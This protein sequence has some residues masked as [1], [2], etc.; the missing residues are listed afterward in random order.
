MKQ[1]LTVLLAVALSACGATPTP[2]DAVLGP[3]PADS[4]F[5]LVVEPPP[6]GH[7]ERRLGAAEAALDDVFELLAQLETPDGES[8][9]AVRWFSAIARRLKGRM[10]GPGLAE[11]GMRQGGYAALFTERGLPVLRME[12]TSGQ[13]F[14]ETMRSLADAARDP[15]PERVWKG[16]VWWDFPLPETP[17][18]VLVVVDGD[19]LVVAISM[20]ET[21]TKAL[22]GLV[23][24]EPVPGSLADEPRLEALRSEHGFTWYLGAVE[25]AR[26]ASDLVARIEERGAWPEH[27]RDEVLGILETLPSVYYGVVDTGDAEVDK[28]RVLVPLSR[29]ARAELEAIVGP[30]PGLAER[31]D[32]AFRA[33][34][35]FGLRVGAVLAWLRRVG[36]TIRVQ[37]YQ[38][39]QLAPLNVFANNV[40]S[41]LLPLAATPVPGLSGVSAAISEMAF[42]DGAPRRFAGVLILGTTDGAQLLGLAALSMPQLLPLVPAAGEAFLLELPAEIVGMVG[43]VHVFHDARTIG[44]SV[45]PGNLE[46]MQRMLAVESPAVEGFAR[47]SMDGEFFAKAERALSALDEDTADNPLGDAFER[48]QSAISGVYARTDVVYQ[49]TETGFEVQTTQR[50]KAP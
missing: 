3:I 38:C 46:R 22:P 9:R 49:L 50:L 12:L 20:E 25:T 27:C 1:S 17:L 21:P 4:P 31:F 5:L 11:L 32:P 8:N 43:P 23:G 34:G 45:G 40:E 42:E 30:P 15:L 29:P 6:A 33:V 39:E 36:A 26:L 28:T 2:R 7:F 13:R 24:V 37:P 14:V 41:Q 10:N 18:R 48:V 19:V 47:A 44:L 16:R 35:G